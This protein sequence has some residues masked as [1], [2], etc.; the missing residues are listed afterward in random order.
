MKTSWQV[1]SGGLECRWSGL[2]DRNQSNSPLAHEA[3]SE[4]YASFAPPLPDFVTHS[5]L[6]SGEWYVPWK[7]R[8]TGPSPSH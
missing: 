4:A 5:L 6:G 8:W 3:S 7:L 1:E 2:L